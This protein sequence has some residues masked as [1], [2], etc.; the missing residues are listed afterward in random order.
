MIYKYI[1]DSNFS[2]LAPLAVFILIYS[3]T[4][5]NIQCGKQNTQSKS[6]RKVHNYEN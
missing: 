6:S 4:Y 5:L 3:R 1:D 2:L